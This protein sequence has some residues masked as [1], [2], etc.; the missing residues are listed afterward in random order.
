M[1]I[2][3][4]RIQNYK[5]FK[6]TQQLEFSPG[7]NVIAGKNNSGKTTLLEAL[8]LDFIAKGFRSF[9]T[10]PNESSPQIDVAEIEL[11]LE[12]DGASLN[13]YLFHINEISGIP[14]PRTRH[15]DQ[16]SCEQYVQEVFSQSSLPIKLFGEKSPGSLIRWETARGPTLSWQDPQFTQYGKAYLQAKVHPSKNKAS[17]AVSSA[18]EADSSFELAFKAKE[19][20]LKKIYKFKA[21][22]FNI[23]TSRTGTSFKLTSNA[24]NLPEV[25][26][27]LSTTKRHAYDEYNKLVKMIFPEIH[28]VSASL[29]SPDQ[30]SIFIHTHPSE[31]LD[32]RFGISEWGTGL[33]Q[34]LAILYVA[35]MES[36]EH[37]LIID[38]PNSFLH[39]GATKTLLGILSSFKHHQYI[40]SSHSAEVIKTPGVSSLKLVSKEAS[41]STVKSLSLGQVKQT[42]ECLLDLGVEISDILSS[43]TCVWVEGP[44]EKNCFPLILRATPNWKDFTASFHSVKNTGDF[45]G[46][47]AEL[48]L[49][50]YSRM[51][52]GNLVIPPNTHFIFDPESRTPQQIE[53][54]KRRKANFIPRKM[55]EN[56]LI[57]VPA[58]TSLLQTL[59]SNGNHSIEKVENWISNN[60]HLYITGA[61]RF[62]LSNKSHLAEV[63]GANLLKKLFADL[64]E[65]RFTYNKVTYG[66]NLTEWIINNEPESLSE[67][68]TFL[69]SVLEK[70][71]I[72]KG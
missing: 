23:G 25:L 3:S 7:I 11:V 33:S 69:L 4:F 60:G 42:K 58:I 48:T 21:E 28:Y 17:Y 30:V 14:I 66:V 71:K 19:H 31:R 53:D 26:H 37:T 10:H 24:S 56:F 50:I 35:F 6:D 51:T 20:F 43:D 65:Q 15:S 1:R 36:K 49:D 64:T 45:E 62:E 59:D 38:E 8:S 70:P 57:S 2:S 32:L 52:E 39:P 44:T 47:G 68:T 55:Y 34:V 54:L 72:T 67:L 29:I 40:I 22:R 41:Q 13:E 16:K 61:D 5:S 12:I 46:R 27:N 18:Q 63:D 9:D